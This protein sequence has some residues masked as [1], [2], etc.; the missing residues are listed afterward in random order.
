MYRHW[1]VFAHASGTGIQRSLLQ[2]V[3]HPT[4]SQV[5]EGGGGGSESRG[6]LRGI[7]GGVPKLIR[8]TICLGLYWVPLFWESAMS[9]LGVPM[10]R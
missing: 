3:A 7:W 2:E 8:V 5:T 6:I 10:K 1:N 9:C 4:S